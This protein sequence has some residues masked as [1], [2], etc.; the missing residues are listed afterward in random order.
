MKRRI[1]SLLCA[2][3][4]IASF[5]IQADATPNVEIPAGSLLVYSK[6]CPDALV[7]Y[8]KETIGEVLSTSEYAGVISPTL[9]TPF[10]FANLESDIYYFPIYSNGKIVYTFRVYETS[11]GEIAG[12]LSPIFAKELN[13]ISNITT[14]EMPLKIYADG[15]NI[16]FYAGDS[17][18]IVLP[19]P[20]AELE[21]N[22]LTIASDADDMFSVIDCSAQTEITP[23]IQTRATGTYLNLFS[24]VARANT[25]PVGNNWCV[26]YSFSAVLNYYGIE[27]TPREIAERFGAKSESDGLYIKDIFYKSSEYGCTSDY[28]LQPLSYVKM[29]SEITAG[30]PVIIPMVKIKGQT[31]PDIGYHVVVVRGCEETKAFFSIWNPWYNFYETLTTL[32]SYTPARQA[33]D[34]YS[35]QRIY[36]TGTVYGIQ[37]E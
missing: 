21:N 30:R 8:A 28:S 10:T 31:D 29:V 14:K 18:E 11:G 36:N 22:S 4:L 17:K 1:V 27:K 26:A 16:V 6:V 5:S 2:L 19:Y 20:I 9:G 35:Y 33:N 37:P 34:E 24:N 12:V 25:Q 13:E 15:N 3:V 23:S 32:Q 7:S